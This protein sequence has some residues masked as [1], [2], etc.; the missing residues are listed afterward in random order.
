MT[1]SGSGKVLVIGAG[2]SGLAAVKCCIDE[3]WYLVYMF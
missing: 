2:A 3:G 1:G